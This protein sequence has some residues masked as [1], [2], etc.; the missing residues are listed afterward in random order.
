M[1]KLAASSRLAPW[2]FLAPFFVVFVVF[3]LYPLA[4]S[5]LLATH[6][7]FGPEHERYVGAR[8]FAAM[9]ADPLF[10]TA[11]RNTFVFALA[12]VFIQLPISLG[13]ALLIERRGTPA[14]AFW[15]VVLFSPAL[16]G[17]VFAAMIFGIILEKRTGLLNVML[18]QLTAGAWNLDFAWTQ[19]YVMSALVVASLW[20]F[21][22]FNMIYFVA[23]LQNVRRDLAEAAVID[24]AGPISR[25]R[26]VTLPAIRPV[27][28]F[29]VLTSI[30][31]SFQLF[32][33]PYLMLNQTA[34]P[35]NRGLT[36]VMYLYQ[37]GF[38]VGDL[39]YAS[40]IGWGLAIILVACTIVQRVLARREEAAA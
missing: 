14:R 1:T 29:V 6:Q 8:N 19:Q 31:G 24:G 15:R 20:M 40:A 22:G 21:V 12:S 38:E 33:L 34:G 7:T 36:I 5:V 35:D 28:G 26:H 9:I 13:L 16:V 11:L 3:T 18:H 17:V 23:A 27:A 25:F 39:G 30:I 2:I 32:E 10:W 37:V 4:R